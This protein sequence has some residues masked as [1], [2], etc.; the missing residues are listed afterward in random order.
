M[1]FHEPGSK[2]YQ[3]ATSPRTSSVKQRP[4]YVARPENAEGVAEVVRESARRG[5]T[6]VPQATGNGAGAEITQ[7]VDELSKSSPEFEALWRDHDIA[8]HAD[9]MKCLRHPELGL[10]EL[11]FSAFAID[12]RPDLGMIVYNPA[13]A[14][15]AQRIAELMARA[16]VPGG[17]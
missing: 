12:G 6:V 1:I 13:S 16:R 9:G 5:L 10:L 4:A 17:C 15:T 7:L 8:Q 3:A 2:T 11:E 14:E